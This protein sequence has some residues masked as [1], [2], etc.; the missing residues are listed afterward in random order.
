MVAAK[1]HMTEKKKWGQPSMRKHPIV[2]WIGSS[3]S[4]ESDWL[5]WTSATG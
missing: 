2:L 3:I 5:R 1:I 4:T